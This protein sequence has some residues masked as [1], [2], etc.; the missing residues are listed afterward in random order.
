MRVFFLKEGR[1]IFGFLS[2]F[3]HLLSGMFSWFPIMFPIVK[4]LQLS[5]GE[6]LSAHFWRCVS[7]VGILY[8]PVLIDSPF[9]LSLSLSLS[10]MIYALCVLKI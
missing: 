7:K 10:I 8:L 3:H 1:M 5:K 2:Y 6:R 9:F 4:P